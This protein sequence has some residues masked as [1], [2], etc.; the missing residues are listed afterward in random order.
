[1]QQ[2][3]DWFAWILQFIFGFVIG[4]FLGFFLL[5][6]NHRR[7]G[8]ILQF[9][10]ELL[11]IFLLGTSLVTGG[12]A[13]LLGDKLWIGSNYRVIPPEEQQHSFLSRGLSIVSMAIGALLVVFSVSSHFFA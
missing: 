6:Q 9:S 4:G 8:A 7:G 11:W 3:A 1:M 2:K 13:S 5:T 10:H 12:L